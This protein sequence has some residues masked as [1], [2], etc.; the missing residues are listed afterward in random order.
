M[1]MYIVTAVYIRR[2]E[3]LTFSRRHCSPDDDDDVLCAY[4]VSKC[5]FFIK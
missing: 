3:K 2:V 1:R 4:T 5:N